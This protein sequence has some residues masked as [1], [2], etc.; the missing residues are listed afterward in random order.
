MPHLQSP[1]EDEL[2][3]V[4]NPEIKSIPLLMPPFFQADYMHMNVPFAEQTTGL[5]HV[6]SLAEIALSRRELETPRLAFTELSRL[7]TEK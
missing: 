2:N 7:F 4:G 1:H 3:D 6:T 5:L